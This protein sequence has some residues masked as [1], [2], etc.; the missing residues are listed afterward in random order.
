M[1]WDRIDG[2]ANGRRPSGEVRARRDWTYR[3]MGRALRRVLGAIALGGIATGG[4]ALG[5]LA[6]GSMATAGCSALATETA[7]GA[8]V[9]EGSGTADEDAPPFSCR[10]ANCLC[11]SRGISCGAACGDGL[12]KRTGWT[13]GPVDSDPS[14][15]F[16]GDPRVFPMWLESFEDA[17]SDT[18]RQR[19]CRGAAV[20]SHPSLAVSGD[21][22]Y[23]FDFWSPDT[24]ETHWANRDGEV[25]FGKV[26]HGGIALSIDEAEVVL[27]RIYRF[28]DV[29][30]LP[31]NVDLSL[32]ALMAFDDG[33]SASD[34]WFALGLRPLAGPNDDGI[35]DPRHPDI[36]WVQVTPQ[37]AA[38]A[39]PELDTV[40]SHPWLAESEGPYLRAE[41]MDGRKQYRV[42]LGGRQDGGQPYGFLPNGRDHFEYFAVY[43]KI[44]SLSHADVRVHDIAAQALDAGAGFSDRTCG[45]CDTMAYNDSASDLA[46][47]DLVAP[48]ADN[49]WAPWITERIC[50]AD[51]DWHL[52][53]GD[54]LEVTV[55]SEYQGT[56]E[57][58]VLGNPTASHL[59]GSLEGEPTSFHDERTGIAG[60]RLLF[61]SLP[62]PAYVRI[63][64]GEGGYR[65]YVGSGLAQ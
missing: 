17:G 47:G 31:Q 27:S 57:V 11:D 48:S 34:S 30:C 7:S 32:S 53:E 26:D 10:G 12:I 8:V 45:A 60:D 28:A 44:G 25:A 6:L 36:A 58:T 1:G 40:H 20:P 65:V 62:H 38:T 2:V 35:E 23:G 39:I 21:Y 5:G 37:A 49:D 56:M 55:D 19:T 13:D 63:A 46:E 15:T 33:T 41:S 50:G 29:G 24:T 52:V 16:A 64:G 59:T 22:P 61:A 3:G 43:L 51:T 54:Y 9:E 4:L 14:H 42:T 18:S